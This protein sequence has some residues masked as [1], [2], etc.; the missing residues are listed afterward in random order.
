MATVFSEKLARLAS[1]AKAA[2]EA[3]PISFEG[4]RDAVAGIW[5]PS[6]S[7]M[8]Q[9]LPGAIVAFKSSGLERPRFGLIPSKGALRSSGDKLE[10]KISTDG[11]STNKWFDSAKLEQEVSGIWL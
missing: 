3:V 2:E 6:K 4:G 7:A 5:Q 8:E 10:V 1:S 11:G 9:I